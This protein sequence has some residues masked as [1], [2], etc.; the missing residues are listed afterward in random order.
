MRPGK[1][2]AI[3]AI[4][5]SI[6]TA[7]CSKDDNNSPQ[8]AEAILTTNRWQ[9]TAATITI[10]GSSLSVNVYDSVPACARDNFYSFAAGGTVTIDEGAS[11]CDPSDAQTT[12]GNWQLLNSNT[13]IKTV[14]PLTGE[15]TTANIVT[16]SSSK[17]VLQDTA[18]YSGFKVTA[19][20]TLT[21]VK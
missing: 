11:K 9:L 5:A 2:L 13:Q 19:N 20:I 15:S 8:N 12:T 10:P 7:A 1:T 6:V 16:L 17:L 14:D 21:N 3:L 18:T 4:A